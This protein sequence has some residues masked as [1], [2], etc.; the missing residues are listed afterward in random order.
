M[1]RQLS[2]GT[3]LGSSSCK[4][5]AG[6]IYNTCL[7]QAHPNLV[8]LHYTGSRVVLNANL[9]KLY[10]YC[11]PLT[12]GDASE[13]LNATFRTTSALFPG[14]VNRGGLVLFD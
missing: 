2:Y 7:R 10:F 3:K 14:G 5:S 4:Y 12:Q 9:I 8:L 6:T 13:R 11:F 1:L